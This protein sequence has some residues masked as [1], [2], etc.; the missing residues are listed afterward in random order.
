MARYFK[1]LGVVFAVFCKA[2]FYFNQDTSKLRLWS[3]EVWSTV[4]LSC[5]HPALLSFALCNTGGADN[6][7]YTYIGINIIMILSATTWNHMLLP[8]A[9]WNVKAVTHFQTFFKFF[10][11]SLL[12]LL[13]HATNTAS[14][15][16]LSRI[17]IFQPAPHRIVAIIKEVESPVCLSSLRSTAAYWWLGWDGWQDGDI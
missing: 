12:H 17:T 15:N 8:R 14:I 9:P 5:C 13:S 10:V 7:A 1:I 6:F 2:A 3:M 4:L 16:L 11:S